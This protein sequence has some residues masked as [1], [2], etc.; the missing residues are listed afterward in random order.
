MNRIP[1][2]NEFISSLEQ[3]TNPDLLCK[4]SQLSFRAVKTLFLMH[5]LYLGLLEFYVHAF[6]I[7]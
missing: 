2:V 6:T 3:L 4:V 1:L 5:I 7:E